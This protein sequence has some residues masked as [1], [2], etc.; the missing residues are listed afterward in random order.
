MEWDKIEVRGD[1]FYHIVIGNPLAF[2]CGNRTAPKTVAFQ[3]ESA[4]P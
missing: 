1:E 4:E 3:S 2:K